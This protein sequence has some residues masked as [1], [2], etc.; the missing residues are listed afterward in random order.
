MEKLPVGCMNYHEKDSVGWLTFPSFEELPFV[1]HAF[2]TRLGGVSTGDFE[3]MNLNFGRGDPRENVEENF[4]RFCAATGFSYESLTASAQDHHTV[5]RRVTAA[6]RGVGITRPKD[7]ESVDGLL[8]DDPSVTLVTYYADCTPLFFADP[9]HRAVGLGHS[10]WRG[11][12]AKM[13]A[14]M[15]RRMAVEFGSRPKDLLV[16][17]GPSIGACCYE[18]DETVAREFLALESLSP[19][20]FLYEAANGKYRLDLWEANRRVLLEAGVLP[21]HISTARLCTKC[22]DRLL[23]SHRAT[24]GVRGG[25]AAFLAVAPK[26]EQ[27]GN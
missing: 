10:G 7:R 3:S 8:T 1:R 4:R 14:C 13:G 19:R 27:N 16:A 11:T 23:W 24:G 18:V 12:A 20:S 9:V 21:E 26:E 15:V 2:S 6:E 5:V 22:N 25:L 17:V